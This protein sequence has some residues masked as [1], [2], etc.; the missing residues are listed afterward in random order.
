LEQEDRKTFEETLFD[1][2]GIGDFL[3]II[4]KELIKLQRIRLAVQDS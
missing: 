3:P 1:A 2:Y 4:K